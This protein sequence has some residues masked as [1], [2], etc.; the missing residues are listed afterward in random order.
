VT[1]VTRGCEH[2]WNHVPAGTNEGSVKRGLIAYR[3][4]RTSRNLAI[5]AAL[6]ALVVGGYLSIMRLAQ[7]WVPVV[8][9]WPFEI[10][11][12]LGVTLAIY[13]AFDAWRC[14]RDPSRHPTIVRLAELGDPPR[15]VESLESELDSG[16]TESFAG[17]TFTRS[18]IYEDLG[19]SLEII[20]IESV[21][22]MY[23]E[24]TEHRK[25]GVITT[26]ETHRVR[27]YLRSG[28]IHDIACQSDESENISLC[29]RQR[30]ASTLSGYDE[31]LVTRWRA[32]PRR[33]I[34][35]IDRLVATRRIAEGTAAVESDLAS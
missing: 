21:A 16:D 20:P 12:W 7:E 23:T 34:A 35:A 8:V 14:A 29:I 25:A 4:G 6:A 10:V 13:V 5:A 32:D 28:E 3:L 18:F 17:V 24:V 26:H 19:L 11:G 27:L 22:W 2:G 33:V 9:W 31:A 15:L 30:S 1:L